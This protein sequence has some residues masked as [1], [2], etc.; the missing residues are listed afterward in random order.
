MKTTIDF[1]DNATTKEAG[2]YFV[3]YGLA[4]ARGVCRDINK[5]VHQAPW[6][7]ICAI[8]IIA[9]VA[10][11]LFISSARAERD[12]ALKA[13]YRLQQQVDQLSCAV[14]AERSAR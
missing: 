11:F 14:Q 2:I 13:Q 8:M 6:L 12:A 7:F 3:R 9:F 1:V 5:A 10:C 4:F